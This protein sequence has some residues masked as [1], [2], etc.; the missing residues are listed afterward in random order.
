MTRSG[1]QVSRN[2]D[3][4]FSDK[5]T[6]LD[7]QSYSNGAVRRDHWPRPK[8]FGEHALAQD[9]P[10]MKCNLGILNYAFN[11]NPFICIT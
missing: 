3:R 6:S 1:S 2:D 11:L 4:L 10:C 9:N 5:F 8:I 7:P